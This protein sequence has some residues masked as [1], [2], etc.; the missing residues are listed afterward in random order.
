[1]ANIGENKIKNAKENT[2]RYFEMMNILLP[3]HVH[4]HT[5]P[6]LYIIYSSLYILF[7]CCLK[8]AA[9]L[10]SPT[11]GERKNAALATCLGKTFFPPDS[12]CFLTDSRGEAI[13][14]LKMK[15]PN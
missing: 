1:M 4:T 3:K 5:L 9:L 12:V 6:Y 10:E 2:A 8:Y 13:H 11:L 15:K 7:G 14:K